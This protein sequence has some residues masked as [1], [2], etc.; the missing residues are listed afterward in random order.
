MIRSARGQ[1]GTYWLPISDADLV[2][3][4]FSTSNL[5]LASE[6]AAEYEGIAQRLTIAVE[7]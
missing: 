3:M 5:A 2:Q 4:S 7:H 6:L 1:P